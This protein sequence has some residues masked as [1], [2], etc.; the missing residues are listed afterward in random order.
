M[1]ITID[2]KMINEFLEKHKDEDINRKDTS[3]IIERIISERRKEMEKTRI[4]G[5]IL[6]KMNLDV[7][8][9]KFANIEAISFY[10]CNIEEMTT[11]AKAFFISNSYVKHLYISKETSLIKL[12]YSTIN[13]LEILTCEIEVLGLKKSSIKTIHLIKGNIH[14]IDDKDDGLKDVIIKGFGHNL[15]SSCPEVGSFIGFKSLRHPDCD[16]IIIA[17]LL[18]T[19]D[20]KRSSSTTRKCRASQ[21]KVL[22]IYDSQNRDI[23]FDKGYSYIFTDCDQ[24]KYEHKLNNSYPDCYDCIHEEDNPCITENFCYTVEETITIDNFDENRWNEC[25]PG[26]HFFPTEI[27]AINY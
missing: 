19:E 8:D 7:L 26:I 5:I 17:K 3:T 10:E 16:N 25:A 15:Y 13:E 1:M 23:K 12:E 21:V 20:A 9:I 22:D 27:E 4:R 2:P 24:C 11:N 14:T 18:I 6:H